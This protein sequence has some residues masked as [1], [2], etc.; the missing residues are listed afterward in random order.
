[1]RST[2]TSFDD[3]PYYVRALRIG[4]SSQQH[5]PASRGKAREWNCDEIDATA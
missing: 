2:V 3:C 4:P 1:M 5:Q